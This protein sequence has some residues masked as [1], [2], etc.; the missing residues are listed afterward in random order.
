[1]RNTDHSPLDPVDVSSLDWGDEAP[2]GGK[3]VIARILKE[4]ATVPLFFGQTLIQSLRDV[5]YNH[6]TQ[7][8]PYRSD[9]S[10]WVRSRG[11][12]QSMWATPARTASITSS[13]ASA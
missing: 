13:D 7:Q 12:R 8:Y 3:A 4:N 1:M 10:S 6:T 5:G 11:R 9:L 2:R